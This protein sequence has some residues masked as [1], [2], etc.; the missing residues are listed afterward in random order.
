MKRNL[1]CFIVIC[2]VSLLGT[3]ILLAATGDETAALTSSV[4]ERVEVNPVWEIVVTGT[5]DEDDT[6]DVTHSMPHNGI[7]Q[8]VILTVPDTTSDPACEVE[9]LDNGDNKVFDS[10]D[11]AAGAS[12]FYNVTE[13]LS[14][15]I[16]IVMGPASA[17]STGG[18]SIVVTLRGI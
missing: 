17:M 10:G 18:G 3:V 4:E 13:P 12:Y 8:K 6:G 2:A 9:I 7:L 5:Y 16:D 15:T 14:G 11:Q 1:L